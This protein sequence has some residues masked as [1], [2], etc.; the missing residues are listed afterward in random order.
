MFFILN[1]CIRL[2]TR[3]LCINTNCMY[4]HCMYSL[5]VTSFLWC[6]GTQSM[7]CDIFGYTSIHHNQVFI[8]LKLTQGQR[9]FITIKVNNCS[10]TANCVHLMTELKGDRQ[11]LW[12]QGCLEN[13]SVT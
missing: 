9:F 3:G 7:H 12:I 1:T 2:V 4:L 5:G 10:I 8:D 11:I 6:A 13:W